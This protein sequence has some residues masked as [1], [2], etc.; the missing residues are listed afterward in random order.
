MIISDLVNIFSL[1]DRIA[2]VNGS[3]FFGSE[4]N[5]CK[6]S[7]RVVII[8]GEKSELLEASQHTLVVDASFHNDKTTYANVRHTKSVIILLCLAVLGNIEVCGDLAWDNDVLPKIK[9]CK[10]KNIGTG[11]VKHLNSNG[12]YYSYGN[13]STYR[14]IDKS[15]VEL[16]TKK[17][18]SN[19]QKQ[20]KID[21]TALIREEIGAN[22]IL[23]A[24]SYLKIF[25][26]IVHYQYHLYLM[27]HINYRI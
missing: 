10:N 19:T 13:S 2:N 26:G 8:V 7:K 17:R 27:L 1:V 25:L 14:I 22:E 24:V 5:L 21:K 20:V 4:I 15:S 9:S 23:T 11:N 16:Y 12:G 18:A 6:M 3:Y